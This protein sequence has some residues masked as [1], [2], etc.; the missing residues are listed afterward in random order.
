MYSTGA[1]SIHPPYFLELIDHIKYLLMLCPFS[2][3]IEYI[4]SNVIVI[5]IEIVIWIGIWGCLSFLPISIMFSNLVLV[6]GLW[7]QIYQ[8]PKKCQISNKKGKK[9]SIPIQIE[10]GRKIVLCFHYVSP[11]KSLEHQWWINFFPV[12]DFLWVS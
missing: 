9:H 11:Y 6:F 4:I 5:E 10:M 2:Y 7:Y 8:H 3:S 12:V 1:S